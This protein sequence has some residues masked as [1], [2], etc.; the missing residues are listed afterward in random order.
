VFSASGI[1]NV[2]TMS[3]FA[4]QACKMLSVIIVARSI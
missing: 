1:S 3:A 2:E 4:L